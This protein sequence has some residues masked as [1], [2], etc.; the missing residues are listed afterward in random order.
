MSIIRLEDRILFE[1]GA[2]VE[3]AEAAQNLQDIQQAQA[4]Q[5]AA[6]AADEAAAADVAEAAEAAAKA[7]AAEAEAGPETPS[8]TEAGPADAGAETETASG[9]AEAEAVDETAQ[10][11]QES[12]MPVADN[13]QVENDALPS[14]DDNNAL[15][16]E[17]GS[18]AAQE[19]TET[20]G[21]NAVAAASD[22]AVKNAPAADSENAGSENTD[23][24]T[25][26]E[27]NETSAAEQEAAD[28][29]DT[30]AASAA[31]QEA[32]DADDTQ[33]ASAA[34]QEAADADDFTSTMIRFASSGLVSEIEANFVS[35]PATHQLVVVCDTF[36]DISKIEALKSST[37]DVLVIAAEDADPLQ[38]VADYIAAKGGGGA[39]YNAL[40]FVGHGDN[41]YF[42]LGSQKIDSAF[43]A[44]TAHDSAFTKIANG[45]TRTDTTQGDVFLYGSYTGKD[46]VFLDAFANKIQADVQASKSNTAFSFTDSATSAGAV[47]EYDSLSVSTKYSLTSYTVTAYDDD[48]KVAGSLRYYLGGGVTS[49][50]TGAVVYLNGMQ[51]QLNRTLE[52]SDKLS[53]TVLGAI[54]RENINPN[55]GTNG[56][57]NGYKTDWGQGDYSFYYTAT[58]QASGSQTTYDTLMTTTAGAT[59]YMSEGKGDLLYFGGKETKLVF[60]N[61]NLEIDDADS[62]TLNTGGGRILQIEGSA[63]SDI[64]IE[65]HN[66]HLK[67]VTDEQFDDKKLFP[68]GV[69]GGTIFVSEVKSLTLD[70][71]VVDNSQTTYSYSGAN[72]TNWTLSNRNMYSD[73]GLIYVEGES[74]TLTISDSVLQ[75]GATYAARPS[76]FDYKNIVGGRGGAVYFAGSQLT[77]TGD[78]TFY[79]TKVGNAGSTSAS[80]LI[81]ETQNQQYTLGGGAIFFAGDK[82]Y[83]NGDA[84]KTTDTVAQ[85][86]RI[87]YTRTGTGTELDPF[88]YTQ[89]S[90][91]KGQA[92]VGD[93]YCY[94][95]VGFRSVN[96]ENSVYGGAIL[97]QAGEV[98][99]SGTVVVKGMSS[100]GLYGAF[101][102][103]VEADKVD[104]HLS[105]VMT[106]DRNAYT[107]TNGDFTND[108]LFFIKN[109][110]EANF[111]NIEITDIWI[112]GG[113]G[114]FHF[115]ADHHHSYANPDGNGTYIT[116]YDTS[117]SMKNILI[118]ANFYGW[119]NRSVSAGGVYFEQ[120][121]DPNLFLYEGEEILLQD[122]TR[123]SIEDSSFVRTGLTYWNS[124]NWSDCRVS[125][126]Q[127][128]AIYFKGGE[129]TVSGEYN[130]VY[131]YNADNIAKTRFSSGSSITYGTYNT[132]TDYAFSTFEGTRASYGSAIYVFAGNLVLNNVSFGAQN[133]T[134]DPYNGTAYTSASNSNPAQRSVYADVSGGA[135]YFAGNGNITANGTTYFTNV[136][137]GG[138]GGII[139]TNTVSITTKVDGKDVTTTYLGANDITFNGDVFVENAYA[140]GY[141]DWSGGIF[142]L[143][144]TGDVTFNGVLKA[145]DVKGYSGHYAPF[146][147]YYGYDDTATIGSNLTFNKGLIVEN[148]NCKV[149]ENGA[150]SRV[151]TSIGGTG[152][153]I[154]FR[155]GNL[156]IA[157]TFSVNHVMTSSNWSG[158]AGLVYFWGNDL[159]IDGN[160]HVNDVQVWTNSSVTSWSL[161]SFTGHDLTIINRDD[162]ASAL[163]PT[164]S[165]L[166][167]NGMIYFYGYNVTLENVWFN[168]GLYCHEKATGTYQDGVTYVTTDG[169]TPTYAKA[170]DYVVGETIK[171]NTYYTYNGSAYVVASGTFLT[172]TVYYK[173]A[174]SNVYKAMTAGTD[175][176]NGTAIPSQAFYTY[177]DGAYTAATGNFAAG[178]TYYAVVQTSTQYRTLVA[179][180]DYTVG[181][182]ISG[183]VYKII[184]RGTGGYLLQ[185]DQGG[186]YNEVGGAVVNIKDFGVVNYSHWTS[187][188]MSVSAAIMTVSN[189]TFDNIRATGDAS[190]QGRKSTFLVATSGS[191]VEVS[192][193]T[194]HNIRVTGINDQSAEYQ[195]GLFSFSSSYLTLTDVAFSDIVIKS[196]ITT[197]AGTNSRG[198]IGS[199]YLGG[200]TINGTATADGAGTTFKNIYTNTYYGGLFYATQADVTLNGTDY[201]VS[202]TNVTRGI[203]FSDI[204]YAGAG[205][206]ND[207]TIW[208]GFYVEGNSV[209]D[210]TGVYMG[211]TKADTAVKSSSI[212]HFVYGAY[213]V[214]ISNS[215][216]E[217]NT[218]G[219]AGG[220]IRMGG[221]NLNID[222]SIFKNNSATWGGVSYISSLSSLTVTNS[223][224]IGNI[225]NGATNGH[226]GVFAF[227]NPWQQAGPATVRSI[228]IDNS[229]FEGN[230]A[231][232]DQGMGGVLFYISANNDGQ[233]LYAMTVTNSIFTGNTAN[234]AGGALVVMSG[235]FDGKFYYGNIA[236]ENSTFTNN[237]VLASGTNL[238]DVDGQGRLK[239]ISNSNGGVFT[240]I[241]GG[242]GGALYLSAETLDITSSTFTG[243]SATRWGGAIYN[244]AHGSSNSG[245]YLSVPTRHFNITDSVFES[246]YAKSMGGA[247]YY[248][249]SGYLDITGSLFSLNIAGKY[250]DASGT[251]Q[252]SISATTDSR[253][254]AIYTGASV[255]MTVDNTTFYGNEAGRGAI[256]FINETG[257]TK[258]GSVVT[259]SSNSMV[260]FLSVTAVGNNSYYTT[261]ATGTVDFQYTRWAYIADSI[262]MDSKIQTNGFEF[263]FSARSVDSSTQTWL[264]SGTT[265]WYANFNLTASARA[266]YNSYFSVAQSKVYNGV[267]ASNAWNA[268]LRIYAD[269]VKNN[270]Y[271]TNDTNVFGGTPTLANN[272]GSVRT[273]ALA[274]NFFTT[275]ATQLAAQSTVR[276]S[277]GRSNPAWGG[278]LYFQV[279]AD[280]GKVDADG[281]AI[282]EWTEWQKLQ[283]LRFGSQFFR[284]SDHASSFSNNVA[285]TAG[286]QTFDITTNVLRQE[287]PAFDVYSYSKMTA[288]SG[289]D[290]VVGTPINSDIVFIQ[291][292]TTGVYEKATGNYTSGVAY[293]KL[294]VKTM[295]SGTDY[296]AGNTISGQ[297]YT[298]TGSGTTAD[299]YLY[300]LATGTYDGSTTYYKP[301]ASSSWT[302]TEGSDYNYEYD[303]DSFNLTFNNTDARG[304]F[305]AQ[306]SSKLTTATYTA[307]DG[308]VHTYY[309]NNGWYITPGAYQLNAT[310]L[311]TGD[312]N[313]S[314]F[315]DSGESGFYATETVIAA[316]AV[317][318]SLSSVFYGT[319][320]RD[321]SVTDE[322]TVFTTAL[323]AAQAANATLYVANRTYTVSDTLSIT[324]DTA[325]S[326]M[327]SLSGL[328]I[329]AAKPLFQI[330]G[331]VALKIYSLTLDTA[332]TG[333]GGLI[334]VSAEHY[335]YTK[336]TVFQADVK[337]Y[338]RSGSG[339]DVDPY[340]YHLYTSY[341]PG[342]PITANTFF[343]QFNGNGADVEIWYSTLK[344][345]NA[346]SLIY[347][348]ENVTV[349]SLLIESSTIASFKTTAIDADAEAEKG[350][351]TLNDVTVV[352]GTGKTVLTMD[353]GKY[354]TLKGVSLVSQTGTRGYHLF[355]GKAGI[356]NTGVFDFDQVDE[357]AIDVLSVERNMSVTGSLLDI[358]AAEKL[359]FTDSDFESLIL[360]GALLNIGSAEFIPSTDDVVR[361]GTVYYQYDAGTGTYQLV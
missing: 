312:P 85:A 72:Q 351:I 106:F 227:Y 77:L 210:A 304:Y 192:N 300:T 199:F 21:E 29:D 168:Q 229:Y 66:A 151:S 232:G 195:G 295:T 353:S 317:T 126:N 309:V 251:V 96:S 53:I 115:I 38:T 143:H 140:W 102:A 226:G 147:Y 238:N 194:F 178:T 253:G 277:I 93:Y 215:T 290:Y 186:Q 166:T 190:W 224:F 346:T 357:I 173:L 123:L 272:G 275:F 142:H 337:Y 222:S 187:G 1:A 179:G 152:G 257:T 268:D 104:F 73:G 7:E 45:I 355:T 279:Y 117:V 132:A 56:A 163:N 98:D 146:I 89:A 324:T 225:A 87:Y 328:K 340:V 234:Y 230:K 258:S 291:N 285:W 65:I 111:E 81:D 184:S 5:T 338:S 32:A 323:T 46:Q 164:F 61:V 141:W 254:G 74:S 172:D 40:H 153:L 332:S 214:S 250:K 336:D 8:N 350:Y 313:D 86:N 342:D 242:S 43:V 299:P 219:G 218:A 124:S 105:Q 92:L 341:N 237:L 264:Q 200:L 255:T 18:A 125:I 2:A 95:T 171:A 155:G 296:Y 177:K 358:G 82:L 197:S 345:A 297:V 228:I 311:F 252:G 347:T 57:P 35:A 263:Y 293:Y 97:I 100:T 122:Q 30:Q 202:D 10:A 33:A 203:S 221:G 119:H 270:V 183:N 138:N 278:Y 217:N 239:Y 327:G 176:T 136:G 201:V 62:K 245:T 349:D 6:E 36:W 182:T 47:I 333:D 121:A 116:V 265:S 321:G 4:E 208:G 247:I 207:S 150:V 334:Y 68:S 63:K 148:F 356:A 78:V 241:Y 64:S 288:G 37:T 131:H 3:A 306:E 256:A 130:G 348:A 22:D 145:S 325:I 243:N 175:Y 28:A 83:V 274:S 113:Y 50:E 51:I 302:V 303:G 343:N 26:S 52:L 12:A 161:I 25:A 129:L 314:F 144:V 134:V 156:T 320:N 109:V 139:Y 259:S 209:F 88:V 20:T 174:T 335:E 70:H 361:Q 271:S 189:A 269:M 11:E 273:I 211:N 236:I 213:T 261:A 193:S 101:F 266:I 305:R 248:S 149:S 107:R 339:T 31:E 170:F 354:A 90:V 206:A 44:G 316:S 133:W 135:I 220:V 108:S 84:W 301:S 15:Q 216:F 240:W 75:F 318:E 58:T 42:L 180:V 112:G 24:E 14:G 329:S 157:E 59:V 310:T 99:W 246:N 159:T 292:A 231:N 160:I 191:Q 267:Q 204:T 360:S 162:T 298:R 120:K 54:G 9:N 249:T 67:S 196:R 41:G 13:A 260:T 198:G 94:N 49:L 315:S 223:S 169:V 235:A 294:G 27:Q 110:A 319:S 137:A 262:F 352:M 280:S 185:V 276:F 322:N 289:K 127:G 34:E 60:Q 205:F 154:Y 284:A 188:M 69:R 344:G 16:T 71:V 103:A 167:G 80:G 19:E 212:A 128:G 48:V 283:N 359:T 55:T 17:A 114:P 286:Y 165:N 233:G 76:M 79:N 287:I 307:Q 281:N 158:G 330:D 181:G 91:T 23:T 326:G 308:T 331:D 244:L 282:Y 39:Y 118:N